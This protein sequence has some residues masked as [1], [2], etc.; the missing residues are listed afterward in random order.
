M[1]TYQHCRHYKLQQN[2]EQTTSS[3]IHFYSKFQ[4]QVPAPRMGGVGQVVEVDE[5]VFRRRKVG[6]VTVLRH[7]NISHSNRLE[8]S[9]NKSSKTSVPS[10]R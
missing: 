6:C 7:A 3:F 2:L 5:S 10:C 8:Y 9:H 4:E 1:L